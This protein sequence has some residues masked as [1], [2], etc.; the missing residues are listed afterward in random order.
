MS[1]YTAFPALITYS[2][3]VL[4]NRCED[5]SASSTSLTDFVRWS[6][7]MHCVSLALQNSTTN[8]SSPFNFSIWVVFALWS[9]SVEVTSLL[10]LPLASCVHCTSAAM[11]SKLYEVERLRRCQN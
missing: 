8:F 7:Y 9:V 1:I 10:W 5:C 2:T 6:F 4:L 3:A 11:N